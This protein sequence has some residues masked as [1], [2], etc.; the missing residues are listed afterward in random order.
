[1]DHEYR[2]LFLVLQVLNFIC[3]RKSTQLLFSW[4]IS[5]QQDL[6]DEYYK[7]RVEDGFQALL[8]AV[9]NKLPERIRPCDIQ[10]LINSFILRKSCGIDGLRY[11]P[12]RPLVHLT[13]LL[14][15]CLRLSHFPKSSK[16]P[17]F[18]TSPK[19]GKAQNYLNI[20]VQLASFP[21]QVNYSIVILNIVQRTLKKEACLTPAILVSVYVTARHCNVW[22]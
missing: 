20:Y 10:K 21:Q 4:K 15:H 5:W 19:P 3:P 14:N 8:E 1:M 6:C 2:L 22:G 9:D 7:R 12:R 16:V 17:K 18:I 11:L 13:H